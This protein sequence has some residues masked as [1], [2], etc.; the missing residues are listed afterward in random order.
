[1]SVLADT[2]CAPSYRCDSF[3]SPPGVHAGKSGF[4]H[5]PFKLGR[6]QAGFFLLLE[7]GA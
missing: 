1:L 5:H 6:Q 7:C 4:G 2:T 3:S